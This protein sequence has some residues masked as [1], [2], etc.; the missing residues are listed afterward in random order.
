MPRQKLKRPVVPIEVAAT[1]DAVK[2]DEEAP[3]SAEKGSESEDSIDAVSDSGSGSESSF[4]L[5]GQ[6]PPAPIRLT[7]RR[8][9]LLLSNVTGKARFYRP[10]HFVLES[11]A[12]L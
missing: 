1:A 8:P 2:Q 6:Y 4:E 9:P 7:P 5:S 3:A 10:S 12:Y 11:V